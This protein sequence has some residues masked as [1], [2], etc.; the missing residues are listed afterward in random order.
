MLN[1]EWPESNCSYCRKIEEAG[2]IS[3]R[4]RQ[5]TI[6]YSIPPELLSNPSEIVV[7]PTFLEVYFSNACNL[8]CLYCSPSLS[9]TI[10][11]ENVKFGK[12]NKHEIILDSI[13]NQVKN[14]APYFWEWFE[15]NF[16]NL[17]RLQV[18]GGEP[19]YQKDFDRLLDYID[20]M[21]NSNCELNVV[22]N[23]MIS[24]QKLQGYIDRFKKLLSAKKLK[25]IDITCSI[26]CFG[27][28]QEY[29]RWGLDLVQWKENFESLL[30]NKWLYININQTIS[31]LTIKTMPELLI[32]L[33]QWKQK[34]Q[35]GH[36]FGGVSPGPSYLMPDIFGDAEFSQDAEI[37]LQLM[38]TK[39]EEDRNAVEY[40]KGIFS[41]ILSAKLNRQEIAKLIVYLDEK[42]RRRGTNWETLFPWLIG[43]RK[44]VV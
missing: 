17:Q 4:K 26:D 33:K 28:Q 36:W 19:L 13:D 27:P 31:P 23:L 25:R 40:M 44:Y 21:P 37:I 7:S 43:Y 5:L 35:L 15:K 20:Q 2:G 29:V 39:T 12:F 16:S 34:R 6:P 3:D 22:T 8:G 10:A 11:A 30:E 41:Q 32:Q 24:K 18:L 9:S 14:L 42:D 38:S 1:G